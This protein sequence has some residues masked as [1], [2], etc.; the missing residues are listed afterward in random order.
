MN[1]SEAKELK[2]QTEQEIANLIQD[3]QEKTGISTEDVSIKKIGIGAE[4]IVISVN[5]EISL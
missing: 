3:Y 5:M 4:G 1:I 2:E